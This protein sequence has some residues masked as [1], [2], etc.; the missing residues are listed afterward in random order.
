MQVD[1]LAA[2]LISAKNNA[3]IRSLLKVSGGHRTSDDLAAAL[4][5]ICYEAWTKEPA[6]ARKAA[7]ALSVLARSSHTE[8]TEGF[9]SWVQGIALITEGKIE[10][11]VGSLDQAASTFKKIKDRHLAAQTQVAKLYCF[12]LLGRYDEAL[13]SG[14]EALRT[15]EKYGDQ[16]AA[17]R[18]E[19][20]IGN[21]YWRREMH[22]GAEKYF[23][24]AR[25]RF[26]KINDTVQLAMIENCLATSYAYRNNFRDAEKFYKK[27][28]FQTQQDGMLVTQAEI[29][30]SLGNLS[31]FRARYDQALKFLELSRRKY[32]SL[33]M[34][35]QMTVAE[36]E[37]ADV[38][39]E[40]NLASE[41]FEI[42]ERV[43][44]SL[45]VLKMQGELA[46]ARSG[47]AQA[48]ILLGK[49]ELAARELEQ[50]ARLYRAEKN[51][52]GAAYVKLIETKLALSVGD[53]KKANSVIKEAERMLTK[54]GDMR[55]ALLFGYLK[56]EVL[57]SLERY[58]AAE[59]ALLKVY[60]KAKKQEN[61]FIAQAAQTS[62]G[63]IALRQNNLKAAEKYF[64]NSVDLI[65][66]LRDPL[67]AEEF[68][69]S[70]FADKLS[71]YQELAKLHLGRNEVCQALVL[72][73]DSR[74]RTLSETAV[75][76]TSRA[77][78]SGAS[79]VR[80]REMADLREEINWFYNRVRRGS[81][82]ESKSLLEQAKKREKKIAE[83]ARRIDNTDGTKRHTRT[84]FDVKILQKKLGAD[85]VMIEY[86][87]L[88]GW[89]GAFV[90]SEKKVDFI[91][92]LASSTEIAELL[93]NMR[94]QFETMRAGSEILAAFF[95][96]LRKRSDL[97]LQ[98]LYEKLLG[99]MEHLIDGHHLVVVP[100]G[101]LHYVPFHALF[102]GGRYVVEER[103]VSYAPSAAVLQ[104]CLSRSVRAFKNALLLGFADE[105]IPQVDKEIRGLQ[106]IFADNL[107]LSGQ[108]ATKT[109]L[110]NESWHYDVAHFACHG[111]F[112]GDNPMFSSLILAD[113]PLNARDI[114]ELRLRPG[115]V[116]LSACETGLNAVAGGDEL[117]GLTRGFISAGAVSIVNTLW[118]IN[119]NAARKLMTEFYKHL[120]NG[121]H[122]ADSL[123]KAQ[124]CFIDRDAPPYLWSPFFLT[125]RW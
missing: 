111:Q 81:T 11:A 107:S 65:E 45:L 122:A 125:G 85:R 119:D 114:S 52:T 47:L 90:V 50:S 41:A 121:C 123:R 115:L 36:L 84:R 79:A 124:R 63:K 32:E 71:P 82:E 67:P 103:E 34:P 37:M 62:L 35:H 88:D 38:Y 20:N 13:K 31:L 9:A 53:T 43:V 56:G 87:E 61:P 98:K 118:T 113:G 15:F 46:R 106:K 8:K 64:R 19:N 78:R 44:E 54:S 4:K 110:K 59:Q 58:G 76:G 77:Q 69:I 108:Q 48:A 60:A 26:L 2:R 92:D 100:F 80:Y 10:A 112:R 22:G 7:N 17:G 116:T 102:D 18:V 51:L 101:K 93:E 73:E 104:Q 109:N 1:E 3:Q 23:L 28:L 33:E 83:L 57:S 42:Y 96:D 70:F 117:L 21:I 29:E 24:S 27:A 86:V 6:V 66:I 25:Q 14:R 55:Y 105:K 89:I 39:L 40:L 12:A 120:K 30:A 91:P 49:K 74:S 75:R 95:D 68:R 97:Y 72:I 16:L 99:K 94:F 5:E